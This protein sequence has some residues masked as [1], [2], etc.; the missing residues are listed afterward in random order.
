MTEV[1]TVSLI[2]IQ[3]SRVIQRVVEEPEEKPQSVGRQIASANT[4]TITQ[5]YE[6]VQSNID[7]QESR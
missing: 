3:L 1:E 5:G 7:R 2:D 4:V 6:R